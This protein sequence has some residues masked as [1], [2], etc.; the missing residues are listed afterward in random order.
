MSEQITFKRGGPQVGNGWFVHFPGGDYAW[1]STYE[2]ALRRAKL[3]LELSCD[4]HSRKNITI[5]EPNPRNDTIQSIEEITAW[6]RSQA[7]MRAPENDETGV[8]L[9]IA[10]LLV[11]EVAQIE[12]LTC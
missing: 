10:D 7:A 3:W 4:D 2:S 6:L 9:R 12:S 1:S 8:L 5:V 11:S